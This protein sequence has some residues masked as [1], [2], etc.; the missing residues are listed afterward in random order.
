MRI[1]PPF[2]TFALLCNFYFSTNG[3]RAQDINAKTFEKLSIRNIGPAGMSGRITAI[4]A[5]SSDP[6]HIFI[7]SASGGVWESKN[8]GTTWSPIFEH[9]ST[10]SIGALKIDQNNPDVIWVGTGEGNPRNSHNEGNGIFKSRDGGKSWTCLGLEET[11]VIHRIHIDPNNSDIVFAAALGTAWGASTERGVYKTTDG[12]KTWQKILYINDRTGA[13]DMIVDNENPNKLFVSMWEHGRSPWS[14]YSGGGGSGLYTTL[15]GGKTWK[16][17]GKNEGIKGDTLGRIGLASAYNK[18][19]VLYALVETKNTQTLYRSN[20]GGFNWNKQSDKNVGNRPFYYSEIYVDP[21]NENRIFNLWSYVSKSEDGGKTFQTIM[22]YGNDIHPDHHA[23][24]IDKNNPNYMIDGN[25]GGLN[26][27]EDGGSNWRFVPNIPVGQFY[28]VN[29][30]NDFPYNVYGGMQDNGSWVGPG[31]AL[32]RGGITNGDWQEI[33]FGDGFD[34]AARQD[35]NRYIYAMSQQGNVGLIDK[36][37]GMTHYI[38]PVRQDSIDLRFSWNAPIAIDPFNACGVY[39]GSQ[40][41]HYS[42]DCGETWERLSDDLTTNDPS[43]QDQSKS[44]GLTLDVTGAENHTTLLVIAPSTLDKDIIWSGS[45][46]GRIH[47]TSNGGKNWQSVES[48]LPRAPQNGWIPQIEVSPHNANEAFVVLNNYR[49]NDWKPYLYHTKDLGKTWT[50]I[51]S[52]DTMQSFVCSIVQDRKD[53]KVLYAGLDDGLYLSFDK[54]K[55]WTKFRHFPSVQ[56]RDM[57]HQE[58]HDDLVLGTFGRSFWVIDDLEII[59]QAGTSSK[60]FQQPLTAWDSEPGYLTTSRSYQGE[61][62]VAQASFKGKNIGKHCRIPYWVSP[63]SINEESKKK[64]TLRVFNEN[65]DTIRTLT[66]K[67]NKGLNFINW[68][69]NSKGQSGPRWDKSKPDSPEPGGPSVLPGK[70]TIGIYTEHDSTFV[71]AQV[72]EDPRHDVYGITQEAIEKQQHYHN[73]LDRANNL[74]EKLKIHQEELDLTEQYIAN[75]PDSIKQSL[76]KEIKLLNTT[77]DSI[78]QLFMLP[79][80]T[81]GYQSSAGKLSALLWPT[82]GYLNPWRNPGKNAIQQ[83]TWFTEKVNELEFAIE[84]FDNDRIRPFKQKIVDLPFRLYKE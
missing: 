67:P 66:Q 18:P 30:D 21:S 58:T 17:L 25:D 73:E 56:V 9:E 13:A 72:L 60:Q 37:T 70:Y 47:V 63:D 79:K 32:K 84:K 44:G 51:A 28:H 2:L 40:F 59:R 1:F 61:R 43:K 75:Q 4:D 26:I 64:V 35:D 62:F 45:D 74:F 52:L 76:Q 53:E 80:D 65:G 82:R 39:F 16:K 49:Q 8:R 19:D 29:I 27:S 81:K 22:D 46:D 57:K 20:D 14:F 23:F 11:K 33:Y 77:I 54:G 3:A 78:Q 31:F 55:R 41:V 7:G 50:N 71:N 24:W 38:K 68:R 5:M 69:L 83:L 6:N 34:V 15:D 12:G 42:P 36:E 48:R 10:M